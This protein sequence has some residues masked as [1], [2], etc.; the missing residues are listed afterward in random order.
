V[1]FIH[2]VVVFLFVLLI[3]VS[4]HEWGHF[5]VARKCGVKVQRFS[6]GF[7]KPFWRITDKHG[8]EFAI[9]PI[10]LGGYVKML[11]AS[12]EN[13]PP[14]DLNKTFES[15]KTWQQIAV[16]VAGPAANF[17]LAIAVFWF[18]GSREV[19]LPSPVVGAVKADSPAADAG[20]EAGQQ[21]IAID[22]VATPGRGDVYQRLSHRLGETGSIMVTVK[23]PDSS[24]LTYNMEV[25]VND[26]LRGAEAPDPLEGLG[27]S[28]FQ[29]HIPA[30]IDT[31]IP[32]SAADQAGFQVG[33]EVV[34]MD[35]LPVP[36]W[37]SWSSYVRQRPNKI[38]NVEVLRAGNLQRL[39]LIPQLVD[40]EGVGSVG[41][42]GVS[43]K[44]VVWPEGMLVIRKLGASAALGQAF[45][46]TWSNSVMV[47]VSVKKLIL[48]EISMKNLSGPIGIAKVAGDSARAG[49][50]Y[51]LNFMAVLS[52]Y[53]GVFNLL[54]I[55]I[56][57]GGRI[58][59][60]LV[61]GI[62][63]QALSER[64]RLVG[65]QL[66]LMFMGVLMIMAFYNDIVRW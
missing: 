4:V 41:Q 14:E 27:L 47:L 17:V 23:Y 36:D 32:Q 37:Q 22:G 53:L 3:L 24:D 48:G 16:L 2:T 63:G 44:S 11:D 8:T 60:S 46:D 15:R 13:I 10:P 50:L 39:S 34:R 57:D 35:G 49:L 56:L 43:V 1:E 25:V 21:I 31:I 7:G 52:V 40:V 28:F 18:L 59:Y 33:D 30:V 12:D 65:M 29:P 61:E 64:V 42:A 54:P 38:V 19:T 55:P 51:Y 58:V 5:I 45:E 26:W 66:G 20:L 6:I 62:R 9:A